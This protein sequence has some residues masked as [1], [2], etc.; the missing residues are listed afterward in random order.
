M[1][2]FMILLISS[3]ILSAGCVGV[4]E[5]DMNGDGGHP[6]IIFDV[7]PKEAR[8]PVEGGE[9]RV[10]VI[11]DAGYTLGVL[12]AWIEELK[13]EEDGDTRTHIFSARALEGEESRNA[14]IVFC[15]DDQICVPVMVKQSFQQDWRK[16]TFYHR[17]V[18]M[19]F[20]A[21][22][23]GFCPQMEEDFNLVDKSMPG[24]AEFLSI[25]SLGSDLFFPQSAALEK[26]YSVYAYP[27]GVI[28]GRVLFQNGPST[29][30]NTVNAIRQTEA[31]YDAVTGVSFSSTVSGNLLI[32]NGT[33]YLKKADKYKITALAVE[34]GIV[35]PQSGA[36]DNYVHDGVVRVS[37]TDISGDEITDV[38]DN[39]MKHFSYSAT[40]PEDCDTD[41]M[42]IVVYIHRHFG[43]QQKIR[44]GDY[45]DYY[46]DNCASGKAG[47]I[48]ELKFE[49]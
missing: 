25:H 4:H 17:S 5:S 33:V 47:A 43:T 26:Q 16:E 8:I 40:V 22:W 23:C 1:K 41:N 31:N 7:S 3:V 34:D 10:R 27:S 42:R 49:E 11:S 24:K 20:T 12:P 35:A 39:D 36:G 6:E 2:N 45:G 14:A 15:N 37:F 38:S 21:T 32:L 13:L 28:D 30:E 9:F 18:A 29:Y 19:R 44:T 48:V 46:I